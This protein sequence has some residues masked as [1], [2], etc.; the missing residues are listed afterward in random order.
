MGA[1]IAPYS[2]HVPGDDDL[3]DVPADLTTLATD[4][5]TALNGKMSRADVGGVP[6]ADT[7]YQKKIKIVTSV[8]SSTSGYEEGD[9]IFVVP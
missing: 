3:A 4:I 8:P 6:G 2:L 5:T 7:L 9:I 1:V